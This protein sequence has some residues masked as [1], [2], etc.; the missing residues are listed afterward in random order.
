MEQPT[1]MRILREQKGIRQ[2]KL[3][4]LVDKHQSDISN[5][6]TGSVTPPA[7]VLKMIATILEVGEPSDLLKPYAEYVK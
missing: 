5:Y 3:A 4:N 1:V 7:D 2:H 6:E